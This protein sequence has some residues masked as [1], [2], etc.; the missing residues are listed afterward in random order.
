M[1]YTGIDLHKK[2]SF[3]TTVDHK[4]KVVSRANLPNVEED[5]LDYFVA[6]EEET[7]IVIE[8]MC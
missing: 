8:S 4:G 1:Y 5:I 6:L 2:T 7:R 3:I